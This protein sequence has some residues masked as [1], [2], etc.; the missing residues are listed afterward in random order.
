[1]CDDRADIDN[2]VVEA[3][4]TC[5]RVPLGF[6]RPICQRD[7]W[8]QRRGFSGGHRIYV[9]SLAQAGQIE[10]ARAALDRLKE[11]QPEISVA[12][13]QQNAPWT[14]RAM[15]KYVEGMRKAGLP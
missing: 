1:M 3:W 8:Q 12:W 13:I 6:L 15:A 11:L 5:S 2:R 4:E 9:A 7:H 10:E 14:P